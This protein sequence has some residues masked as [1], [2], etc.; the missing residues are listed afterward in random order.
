MLVFRTGRPGPVASLP[1]QPVTRAVRYGRAETRRL[2]HPST[3]AWTARGRRTLRPADAILPRAAA[4]MRRIAGRKS[5]FAPRAAA[6]PRAYRC[7]TTTG[8]LR[9]CRRSPTSRAP[10]VAHP[11]ETAETR[12]ITWNVAR[13]VEALAAQAAA[14]GGREPDVV[15]LQEVTAR[16]LPLWEAALAAIGLPHVACT[17]ATAEPGRTP[18]GPRRTGVL[19]AARTPLDV[20]PG[21]LP[22]P[23]PETALAAG[24]AGIEVHTVHVPNAANGWIKPAHARRG[25]RRA[26]RALRRPRAVRRP[27]HAAPRGA[28]RRRHVVR[29]RRA[30][31]AAPGARRALG[32]GRARRRPGPA[33]SRIPRRLPYAPRLRR[34]RAELDVA[35]HRGPPWWLAARSRLLLRGARGRSPA[36][37]T[38]P[39]ATTGSATTRR[40]RSIW[41]C[42]T[43]AAEPPRVRTARARPRSRASSRDTP[44]LPHFARSA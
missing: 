16:T 10:R 14:L 15:A 37:T 23:W 43:P 6:C 1:V 2:Q 35:P 31:A 21:L 7:M 25:A 44:R 5:S 18:A 38:T 40:S 17:L 27:Q 4:S 20:R 29:A 30:W 28:G 12:L 42:A 9:P 19:L 39:G 11:R 36:P 32:R 34:A 24:V 13:R 33:R 22:V 3:I 41:P 26:G 8:R